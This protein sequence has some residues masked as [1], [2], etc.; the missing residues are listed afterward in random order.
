LGVP[1]TGFVDPHAPSVH[2]GEAKELQRQSED[3]SEVL[4]P[5]AGLADLG[6]VLHLPRSSRPS[7]PR[8]SSARGNFDWGRPV[9]DLHAGKYG[10][11][12]RMA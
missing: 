4:S 8:D 6:G 9:K 11:L 12:T 5:Q 1:E 3:T 2:E 7:V 10:E